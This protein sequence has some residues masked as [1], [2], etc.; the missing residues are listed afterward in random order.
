MWLLLLCLAMAGAQYTQVNTAS[1]W[2]ETGGFS[3]AGNAPAMNAA[4]RCMGIRDDGAGSQELVA[5]YGYIIY[6]YPLLSLS[7]TPLCGTCQIYMSAPWSPGTETL[8]LSVSGSG[9]VFLLRGTNSPGIYVTPRYGYNF[10]SLGAPGGFSYTRVVACRTCETPT[11]AIALDPTAGR[12]CLMRSVGVDIT[13]IDTFALSSPGGATAPWDQESI[14]ITNEGA[15]FGA[16][17]TNG[18]LAIFDI[19]TMVMLNIFSCGIPATSKI[20][21]SN[22]LRLYV[23][24]RWNGG[25]SILSRI[26][27]TESYST[28]VSFYGT[29]FQGGSSQTASADAV[30]TNGNG[31]ILWTSPSQFLVSALWF[32]NPSGFQQTNLATTQPQP[33]LIPHPR[34]NAFFLTSNASVAQIQAIAGPAL[35]T[36]APTSAPTATPTPA[37]TANPTPVPTAIPTARPTVQPTPQPTTP[38]PTP[39]P[40][41]FPTN[42][43]TPAPTRPPTPVP[44][45]VPT[46]APTAAPT[47]IPTAVPTAAPTAVPTS[48]PTPVPTVVP[49]PVPTPVP[50]NPTA[51]PTLSPTPVPT[52]SPTPAPTANPTAAPTAAPT[53]VPTAVPTRAPTAVPTAAPTPLPGLEYPV[54]CA[55]SVRYGVAARLAPITCP[56]AQPCTGVENV[57]CARTTQYMALSADGKQCGGFTRACRQSEYNTL[58]PSSPSGSLLTP[59]VCEYQCN[60]DDTS[61]CNFRNLSCPIAAS[62]IG[63]SRTCIDACGNGTAYC[64]PDGSFVSTAQCTCA[65][66][67]PQPT[68]K[69][70]P[71]HGSVLRN[72]T[73]DEMLTYCGVDAVGGC[74]WQRYYVAADVKTS[75]EGYLDYTREGADISPA[76]IRSLFVGGNTDDAFIPSARGTNVLDLPRCACLGGWKRPLPKLTRVTNFALVNQAIYTGFNRLRWGT[77][78]GGQTS[79]INMYSSINDQFPATRAGT[80]NGVGIIRSGSINN[81]DGSSVCNESAWRT[82]RVVLYVGG[83]QSLGGALPDP[84]FWW[85]ASHVLQDVY[86]RNA[87]VVGYPESMQFLSTFLSVNDPLSVNGQ[88]YTLLRTNPYDCEYDYLRRSPCNSNVYWSTFNLTA[89]GGNVFPWYQRCLDPRS[90]PTITW[91]TGQTVR[92][93]VLQCLDNVGAFLCPNSTMG[94]VLVNIERTPQRVATPGFCTPTNGGGALRLSPCACPPF[95]TG[96]SCTTRNCPATA[97]CALGFVGTNCTDGSDCQLPRSYD[98]RAGCIRGTFNWTSGSCVCDTGWQVANATGINRTCSVSTCVNETFRQTCELYG[99]TC[100]GSVCSGCPFGRAGPDCSWCRATSNGY[101]GGLNCDVPTMYVPCVNGA[102]AVLP[103]GDMFCNCTEGWGGE[104]CDVSMCPV[105]NG[106]VCAG[107]GTC[108]RPTV[109]SPFSCLQWAR[110]GTCTGYGCVPNPLTTSGGLPV[111]N[112]SFGGCACQLDATRFCMEPGDSQLCNGR[113]DSNG[114]PVCRTRAR[115]DTFPA[116]QEMFCDCAAAVGST[117]TGQFCETDPCVNPVDG[118]FG[119]QCS[120]VGTCLPGGVC[121]CFNSTS[122]TDLLPGLGQYCEIRVPTCTRTQSGQ[123]TICNSGNGSNPCVLLGNGTYVCDCTDGRTPE[124]KCTLVATRAPTASPTRSPTPSPTAVPTPAPTT[125]APTALPGLPTASPTVAPSPSPTVAPTAQPSAVPTAAPTT[126]NY[127]LI[128][129]E[130]CENGCFRGE[131]RSNAADVNSPFCVCPFPNVWAFD[132]ITSGC[133][134][135][136]CPTNSTPSSSGTTCVCDDPTRIFENNTCRAPRACPT[137]SGIECGPPFPLAAGQGKTCNDGT[138]VCSGY[139]VQNT[140]C[141]FRCSPTFTTGLNGTTCVCAP[142]FTSASGCTLSSCPPPGIFFEGVCVTPSPTAGTR[143]FVLLLSVCSTHTGTHCGAQRSPHAHPIRHPH[144]GP[145]CCAHS[146]AHGSGI[147]QRGDRHNGDCHHIRCRCGGCRR[148]GCRDLLLRE[149]CTVRNTHTGGNVD[150]NDNA[151]VCGLVMNTTL[152]C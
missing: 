89:N 82:A 63:L 77:C 79:V 85:G 24:R 119:T 133:E 14:Y 69:P 101:W 59:P 117:Y 84:S 106:L 71:Q 7:T 125:A 113:L 54:A 67:V 134:R 142:G 150:T 57:T 17:A 15:Y 87:T 139:Y 73:E 104:S 100:A 35:T 13:V 11:V 64:S 122:G 37:P 132:N 6:R 109:G 123:S 46:R 124:S 19:T 81:Y 131:C 3:C 90:S 70:C 48:V 144:G 25:G 135:N 28:G 58:C 105:V 4:S 80:C 21:V 38:P 148:G 55:N 130:L 45:A 66:G 110:A 146:R 75:I 23:L 12:I 127:S 92:H 42:S 74:E 129:N 86:T 32:T 114:C 22:D 47:P 138:C 16:V 51:V 1:Y 30:I 103:N 88:R 95:L 147:G 121:R 56:W 149:E 93:P 96:Y 50:G 91:V 128:D 115:A 140:T 97:E 9:F 39:N 137:A 126:G 61:S 94:C 20:L 98:A 27:A 49:T 141:L 120:G 2:L 5:A 145:H 99:G 53:P 52:T 44:T 76:L 31:F 72:C 143:V 152:V 43:P 107:A 136:A 33:C 40:T 112:L 151:K 62:P 68:G 29:L 36:T 83:G 108:A 116:T 34:I 78:V 41:L 118:P 8:D 102:V 65:D 26:V 10:N 60:L 111:M 18:C